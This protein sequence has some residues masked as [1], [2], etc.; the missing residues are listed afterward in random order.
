MIARD[1][2]PSLTGGPVHHLKQ[3]MDPRQWRHLRVLLKR[4]LPL[5]MLQFVQRLF[6]DV[7]QPLC[8]YFRP[9]GL[10]PLP[11]GRCH[12]KLVIVMGAVAEM[13]VVTVLVLARRRMNVVGFQ[14]MLA[15][16]PSI[17]T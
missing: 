12:L 5:P 10:K 2:I 1:I 9:W 4:P 3:S 17:R 15:A 11:K 6:D 8:P 16:A 7:D 14:R 13:R